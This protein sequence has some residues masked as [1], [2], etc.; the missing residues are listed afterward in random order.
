MIKVKNYLNF[1]IK[2]FIIFLFCIT[3]ANFYIKDFKFALITALFFSGVISIILNKIFLSKSEKQSIKK[4]NQV[5]LNN[6]YNYLLFA[7]D[8]E[9]TKLIKGII[10]TKHKITKHSGILF[11]KD[12]PVFNLISKQKVKT[13]DVL[14]VIK[15]LSIL[16]K[17]KALLFCLQIDNDALNF[18]NKIDNLQIEI[19]DYLYM[20]DNAEKAKQ[21]TSDIK[22]KKGLKVNFKQFLLILFNKKNAKNFFMLGIIMLISSFFTFYSFYY[23]LYASIMFALTVV[24]LFIKPQTAPK[25]F[26]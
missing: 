15:S 2:N 18:I 24:C 8:D 10:E 5:N 6:F 25:T 19:Y 21:L 26:L 13:D 17:N 3:W 14:N 16:G 12:V 1:I 22:F 20:F 4:E 11:A 9:T 23:S 7:N